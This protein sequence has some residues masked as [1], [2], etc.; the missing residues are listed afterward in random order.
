MLYHLQDLVVLYF[1]LVKFGEAIPTLRHLPNSALLS[2]RS[3]SLTLNHSTNELGNEHGNVDTEDIEPRAIVDQNTAGTYPQ[4]NQQQQNTP[5]R[6]TLSSHAPTSQYLLDCA[7]YQASRDDDLP[8][9]QSL[10]A[11]GA[12]VKAQLPF[13]SLSPLGAATVGHHIDMVRFLL[14]EGA[15]PQAASPYRFTFEDPG[16][17]GPSQ[18][19][20]QQRQ[21]T[22]GSGTAPSPSSTSQTQLDRSLYKASQDGDLGQVQS[23]IARGA[24]VNAQVSRV[25]GSALGAAAY[26]GHYNVFNFLTSHGGDPN[27]PAG[28]FRDAAEANFAGSYDS[29]HA[30]TG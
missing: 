23:A 20:T 11:Q 9:V 3:D 18:G 8:R 13:R 17:G 25:Y 28:I 21:N 24:N 5:E 6:R 7:L 30:Y 15:D 10:I 19:A 2:P 1:A 27:T 22:P 12:N 4:P 14:H 16:Q 29:G 26:K